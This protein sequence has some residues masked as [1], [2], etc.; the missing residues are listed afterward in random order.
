[1]V[2]NATYFAYRLFALHMLLQ[3]VVI[4]SSTAGESDSSK[5]P[6]TAP[7]QSAPSAAPVA[8]IS[9]AEWNITRF[10]TL[11]SMTGAA[12]LANDSAG[13]VYDVRI[14]ITLGDVD[15]KTLATK[16]MPIAPTMAAHER[17][18]KD[19]A[20]KPAPA[21]ATLCL[22]VSYSL[23]AP[24]SSATAQ[25]AAPATGTAPADAPERVAIAN[26]G[27]KLVEKV[28]GA[29][30]AKPLSSHTEERVTEYFVSTSTAMPTRYYVPDEAEQTGTENRK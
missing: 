3:W 20:L 24:A 18:R 7:Q 12:T 25:P 5:P 6:L 11:N 13:T 9:I 10:D 1:M 17:I 8:R 2:K 29:T 27:A 22:A 14:I 30:A 19:I 28:G 23:T 15:G 26:V 21:F 4:Y 16:T